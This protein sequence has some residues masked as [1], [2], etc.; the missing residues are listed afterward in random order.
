[1]MIISHCQ[2]D[3]LRGNRWRYGNVCKHNTINSTAVH[4]IIRMM[5]VATGVGG[6]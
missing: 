1:M 4:R 3:Y 6:G 5:I 2:D